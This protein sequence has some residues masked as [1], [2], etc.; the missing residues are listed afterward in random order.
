MFFTNEFFIDILS[1][2]MFHNEN[3]GSSKLIGM[4]FQKPE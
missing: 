4:I 2:C 1:Q 3:N